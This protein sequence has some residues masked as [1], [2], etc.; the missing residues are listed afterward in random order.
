VFLLK[1]VEEIGVWIF[2]VQ[3]LNRRRHRWP[4]SDIA[5]IFATWG[6]VSESIFTP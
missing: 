1:V 3:S 2:A 4:Y 5:P 6:A